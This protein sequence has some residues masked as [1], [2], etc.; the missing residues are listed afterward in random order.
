MATRELLS[1]AQRQRLT[2]LPDPMDERILARYHTLSENDLSVVGKRRRPETKLGFAVQLC[3]LRFPGRPL[4]SGERPPKN[5][6]E[7]GAPFCTF[8]SP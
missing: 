4:K 1:Q 8:S 3:Y 2:E 7:Y 5:L 6:L